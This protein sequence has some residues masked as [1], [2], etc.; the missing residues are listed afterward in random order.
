M[1]TSALALFVSTLFLA[2]CGAAPTTRETPP[3]STWRDPP[4]RSPPADPAAVAGEP[5]GALLAGGTESARAL[6][7]DLLEA[8]RAD[9]AEAAER[10]LAERVES[11][12]PLRSGTPRTA[13]P[14]G[15]LVRHWLTLA[16]SAHLSPSTPLAELVDPGGLTVEPAGHHYDEDDRP[17]AVDATDLVVRFTVT[18]A[19]RRTFAGLAPGGVGVLIVRPGPAPLII[20]R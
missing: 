15:T 17:S 13:T 3:P 16:R 1:R 19:G 8:L 6:V 12:A 18:D 10:T 9:D 11:A 20:A 5:T 4:P 2:A 14:R 7:V